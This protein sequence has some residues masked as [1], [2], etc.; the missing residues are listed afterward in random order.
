MDE[1][2]FVGLHAGLGEVERERGEGREDGRG[3]GADLGAVA[4][5]ESLHVFGG[6]EEEDTV[7]GGTE[8]F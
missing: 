4:F 3:G 2:R 6:L 5:C 1:A 8:G 7:V